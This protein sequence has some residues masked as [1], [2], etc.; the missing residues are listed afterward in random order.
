MVNT[1][2]PFAQINA[3]SMQ[4]GFIL[5]LWVIF[6]HC[7]MLASFEY[8]ILSLVSV[9][10]FLSAPIVLFLLTKQFR[11]T[12]APEGM[13]TITQGFL[14]TFLNMVYASTWVAL[15][16][17][18]YFT[19]LDKGFVFDAYEAYLQRPEVIELLSQKEIQQ[20]MA[21]SLQGM[22]IEET[23]NG[24][25][26]TP[27]SMFAGMIFYANLMVAPIVSLFIAFFLKRQK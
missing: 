21:V 15:A 12:V 9:F 5:G 4:N 24:F 14:H 1:H 23:L 7:A 27:P 8:E 17:F 19:Y 10:M 2:R 3:F 22:T 20:Q 11:K 26:T 18:V 6:A 13:F 16:I 25:R